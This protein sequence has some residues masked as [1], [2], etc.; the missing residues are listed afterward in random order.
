MGID[1]SQRFLKRLE[2]MM[3]WFTPERRMISSSMD[4]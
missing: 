2:L 4:T 3:F 1:S